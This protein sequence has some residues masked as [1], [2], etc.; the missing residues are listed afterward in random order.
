MKIIKE[1]WK[2][3]WFLSLLSAAVAVS[4]FA[5]YAT[6]MQA[7]GHAWKLNYAVV[8]EGRLARSAQPGPADLA[9]IRRKHGLG[10]ILSLR[11]KEEDPVIAW[12][13]RQGIKV[14]VFKMNADIPPTRHQVGLF[15]DIMRG[16]TVD[17]GDYGDTVRKTYGIQREKVR[18]PFPVLVHCAHGSD[19]AGVMIAVYRMAFQ[20]WS[21]KKSQKEMLM[22][23]HVPFA[24][25][26]LFDYLEE[27][28]SGISPCFGSEISDCRPGN[29][30]GASSQYQQ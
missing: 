16:D 21:A 7:C 13:K 2:L 6:V 4:F 15:F 3:R 25:P 27:V 1:S 10:T 19:R 5:G 9:I 24:H 18:L 29:A 8:E 17:F 23:L 14:V 12:A 26:R 11:N 30:A 20:G 22:H 28:S